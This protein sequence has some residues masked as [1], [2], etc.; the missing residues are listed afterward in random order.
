MKAPEKKARPHVPIGDS[1]NLTASG[2][3]PCAVRMCERKCFS[4]A[5]IFSG[6]ATTHMSSVAFQMFSCCF[7]VVALPHAIWA[8]VL[9]CIGSVSTYLLV[10]GRECGNESVGW[11]SSGSFHF[12]FSA[13]RSSTVKPWFAL[14]VWLSHGMQQG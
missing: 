12:L 5:K 8:C 13:Y 11:L 10:L 9:S 4:S 3:M 2:L 14:N 6:L 7:R 1:I